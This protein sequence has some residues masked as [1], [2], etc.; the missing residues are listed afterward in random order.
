VLHRLLIIISVWKDINLY[1]RGNY[2]YFESNIILDT[3][4]YYSRTFRFYNPRSYTADVQSTVLLHRQPPRQTVESNWA[5]CP[6]TSTY[7]YLKIF[8]IDHGMRNRLSWYV[9]F[10][11]N[12]CTSLVGWSLL[13]RNCLKCKNSTNTI[14]YIITH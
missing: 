4:C 2:I 11:L 13:R 3:C 12:P 9:V 14:E 10:R 1:D 5:K 8:R 7:I 6:G